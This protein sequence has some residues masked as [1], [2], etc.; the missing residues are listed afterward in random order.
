MACVLQKARAWQRKAGCCKK[1]AHW[2]WLAMI[3]NFRSKKKSNLAVE[4][5]STPF[6]RSRGLMFRKKAVPL[7]FVFDSIG[8]YPIH[9]L[10]VFFPFDSIYLS[11]DFVVNELY[12]SVPPFLPLL[13]PKVPSKYLLELPAGFAKK[14]SIKKGDALSVV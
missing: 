12:E 8:I 11:K 6:A 7:L 13:T 10:F 3:K 9:S 5:L 2:G 14:L 4:M 1:M